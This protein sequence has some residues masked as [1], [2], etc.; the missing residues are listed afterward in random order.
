MG[1]AMK[2]ILATLVIGVAAFL[3]GPSLWPPGADVPHPP[4]QLLPAYMLLG[5]IE[6]LGFGLAVAFLLLA[7]PRVRA[8][9][10]GPAWL[11]RALYVSVAWLLGNWW[12]HDGLHMNVG[13]DMHRL[14]YIEYAFH[15]TLLACGAVLAIGFLALAGT[16]AKKAPAR[17]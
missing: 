1:T 5:A 11:N 15:V 2:A 7:W 6:A 4:E 9:P 3:A 12:I 14:V 10:L 8:L 13:L 17:R 16:A